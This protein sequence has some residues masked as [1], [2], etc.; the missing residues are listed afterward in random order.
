MNSEGQG[1]G[2]VRRRKRLTDKETEERMM[3]AALDGIRAKGLSVSVDHFNLEELI[4]QAGVA[5]SAVYR[6]WPSKELFFAQFVREV[7][8]RNRFAA[9]GVDDNLVSGLQQV[10]SNRVDDLET[11]QGRRAVLVELGRLGADENFRNVRTSK[12]FQ[13]HIAMVATLGSLDDGDFSDEIR[14]SLAQVESKHFEQMVNLYE[15]LGRVVGYKPC[16]GVSFR[17]IAIQCGAV[18]QG[19]AVYANTN[20]TD[21]VDDHVECDPFGVGQTSLWSKVAIAF[22]AVLL[23]NVEL[24]Q[25]D[26]FRPKLD[27][28]SELSS[29]DYF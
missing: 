3:A 19:F 12:E 18:V 6:K 9:R 10:V 26:T 25:S 21:V 23:A 11:T 27:L 4:R 14:E 8:A 13:T 1:S 24:D 17:S 15:L 5:R 7:A 22:T 28:L 29:G 2:L 20:K 16:Q